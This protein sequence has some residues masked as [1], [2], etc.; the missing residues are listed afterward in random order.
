MLE[1]RKD[2]SES[3]E[4]YDSMLR[5]AIIGAILV[6]AAPFLVSSLTGIDTE[7]GEIAEEAMFALSG[8]PTLPGVFL[9][10]V[11]A[12]YQTVFWLARVVIVLF[13]IISVI[14]LRMPVTAECKETV[15]QRRGASVTPGQG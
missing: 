1:R 11:K 14:M 2:E 7:S 15:P 4:K 3:I 6:F 13:I 5:N 10:S 12:I 9:D 8:Q